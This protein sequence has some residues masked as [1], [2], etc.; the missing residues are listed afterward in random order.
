MTEFKNIFIPLISISVLL[1]CQSTQVKQSNNY[2]SAYSFKPDYTE[3]RKTANKLIMKLDREIEPKCKSRNVT[4]K[5]V[6]HDRYN[7]ENRYD[8]ADREE[9]WIIDRC[10][11]EVRYT[12]N[13]EVRFELPNNLKTSV[14]IKPLTGRIP[15]HAYVMNIA[16]RN[17]CNISGK[18]KKY[19]KRN[20]RNRVYVVPCGNSSMKFECDRGNCW[21]LE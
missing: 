4:K 7:P 18:L 21:R 20:S 10:G 9:S 6:Y 17:K 12:V 8:G 15:E 5:R 2:D 14:K 3:A 11:E 1:G 19:Q 16:E 13:Y